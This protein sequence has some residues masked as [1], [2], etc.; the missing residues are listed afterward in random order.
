MWVVSLGVIFSLFIFMPGARDFFRNGAALF[1]RSLT[2]TFSSKQSGGLAAEIDLGSENSDVNAKFTPAGS[3]SSSVDA[4]N[5]NSG[6]S[7][8]N[9][10][11]SKQKK[12]EIQIQKASGVTKQSESGPFSIAVSGN[13]N[14]SSSIGARQGQFVG[15]AT[16]SL[17]VLSGVHILISSVQT[18]G[19]AKLTMNDFI[20][21]Y[22]P[23]S[24]PFN[25]KGYRLVK[26]TKTGT[27]DTSIKSWIADAF[28]P[29]GGYYVWANSSF[30][31]LPE[32]SNV[33][34]TGSVADDNGVAIRLGAENSGTIMDS[35]AWGAAAN[36][37]VE[38]VAYPLNPGA[39]QI[40]SRKI[41]NGVMQDTNN[42]SADFEIK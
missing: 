41:S 25:L 6:A 7:A 26:R 34:T 8:S 40:L 35:V 36:I 23:L 38:G 15:R 37:F 31:S 20:K 29:A 12:P 30:G 21:I 33:T 11:S 9:I 13:L 19:G 17:S 5:V 3:S 18:T 1:S 2:D 39:N 24:T 27:T 16:S 28:I 10:G 14:A 22:N 32:I 4:K 42:N